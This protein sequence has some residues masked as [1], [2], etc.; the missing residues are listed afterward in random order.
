ME[1]LLRFKF[2]IFFLFLWSCT[3]NYQ[4]G[5]KQANDDLNSGILKIKYYGELLENELELHE[6]LRLH[7]FIHYERISGCI[8]DNSI[9]EYVDGYNSVMLEEI[10]NRYAK[11]FDDIR[12]EFSKTIAPGM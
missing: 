3:S 1:S 5:L 12:K 9:I 8:V 7:Y 4:A 10:R 2:A 11:G 6:F